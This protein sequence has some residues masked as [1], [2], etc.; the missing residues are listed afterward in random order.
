MLKTPYRLVSCVLLISLA[1]CSSGEKKGAGQIAAKV[2]GDE[3]S[4]GLLNQALSMTPGITE[5]NAAKARKEILDKLIV[6]ELAVQKAMDAKL[7]R[8][9]QVIMA[10][11]MARREVLARAYL[12]QISSGA[13]NISQSDI[14]KYFDDHPDLFTQRRIYS[15][16][17]ISVANDDK[18][19]EQLK[20]M[21]AA[22]KSMQDIAQWLKDNNVKFA[23]NNSV[24]PAEQ[25]P[26]DILPSIAKLSDGQ[27]AVIPQSQV[28]HVI[29]LVK[30]K[31]EPVTFDQASPQIQKYLGAENRQQMIMAEVKR[32]KDAA[33]I[34]YFGEFSSEQKKPSDAQPSQEK[35]ASN[36]SSDI[37]K[38]AAKL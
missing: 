21:V 4:V 38:G 16:V 9:P 26:L 32:L 10:L 19:A 29:E 17:D 3:I 5:A 28:L 33:K 37:A 15:L 12:D 27:A 20:G 25:L 22:N 13:A 31:Q 2:N 34:E 6:Q 30:S 1:A 7:D 14:R 23:A 35:P 36:D 18:V 11:D 8:T 24:N